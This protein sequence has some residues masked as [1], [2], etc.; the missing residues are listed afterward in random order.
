ML[1]YPASLLAPGSGA[2]SAELPVS[3]QAPPAFI[4]QTEDDS[5][6]VENSLAYY[7]ALKAANVAVEMHLYPTG[8]HGYGL[9][10]SSD[11]VSTWPARAQDWLRTLGVLRPAE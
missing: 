1:L 9:R 6:R 11:A 5:V 10:P 2:L 4:V 7:A 8:G 3:A